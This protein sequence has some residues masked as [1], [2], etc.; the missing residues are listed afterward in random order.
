[1][2]SKN[3]D[4]GFVGYRKINFLRFFPYKYKFDLAMKK[5]KG[6]LG[7]SFVQTW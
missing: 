6:N 4:F 5:V 7:S 1:M 2:S 3:I